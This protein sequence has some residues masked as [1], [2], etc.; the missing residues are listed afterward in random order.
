MSPIPSN[1]PVRIA[2]VRR[3]AALARALLAD[4][5]RLMPQPSASAHEDIVGDE[6]IEE[7]TRLGYQL[8][9]CA[10]TM[11]ASRSEAPG[12]ARCEGDPQHR[13]AR[14]PADEPSSASR[15]G[16]QIPAREGRR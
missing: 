5:D 7:L 11:A 1:L 3:H 15:A 14:G 12:L 9:E 8:L 4:L 16:S 6:V 2:A 10:A 13:S